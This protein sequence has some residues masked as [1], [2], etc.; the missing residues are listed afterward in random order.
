M[1]RTTASECTSMASEAAGSGEALEP[2]F[3][4]KATTDWGEV[5]RA[6][7]SPSRQTFD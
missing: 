2:D 6:V 7:H 1:Q 3:V 4:V 5:I